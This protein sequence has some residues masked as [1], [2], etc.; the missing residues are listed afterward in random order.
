M[1]KEQTQVSS[2]QLADTIKKAILEKKGEN[3][4]LLNL[5][6][7]QTAVCDYFVV[8]HGNSSTQVTAI[9]DEIEKEVKQKHQENVYHKEGHENAQW[10]LLDYSDVVVHV[11][12][13]EAREYYGLE[14][15]WADAPEEKVE[16]EF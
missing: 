5:K 10:I 1:G 16:L 12:Q 6:K 3:V 15:L 8:C 14:K 7:I 2:K 11:F 9:A 4:V 13:A